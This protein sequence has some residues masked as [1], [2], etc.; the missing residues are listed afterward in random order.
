MYA[1]GLKLLLLMVCGTTVGREC[2]NKTGNERVTLVQNGYEN[3]VVA[4]AEGMDEADKD[5]IIS[6]IKVL[7][8][9]IN[10][11]VHPSKLQTM[12]FVCFVPYLFIAG[13]K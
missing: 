5:G 2:G 9:F 4:I 11:S 10:Q 6:R 8:L 1:A 7:Y 13:K 3:I 12:H